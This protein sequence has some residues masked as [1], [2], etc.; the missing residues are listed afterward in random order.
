VP[1]DDQVT[2]LTAVEESAVHGP[3][4]FTNA[5]LVTDNLSQSDEGIR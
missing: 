3:A 2:P 5:P 1:A 4:A